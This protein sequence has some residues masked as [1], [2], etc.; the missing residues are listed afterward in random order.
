M[1]APRHVLPSLRLFLAGLLLLCCGTLSAR[2]QASDDPRETT[3]E[4]QLNIT[5]TPDDVLLGPDE[6]PQAW[7]QCSEQVIAAL[8]SK[9]DT[10]QQ[11]ALS[12]IIKY[13][14]YVDAEAAV[15]EVA[16]LILKHPNDNVR[17]LAVTALGRMNNAWGL[18]FLQR[19]VKMET[20]PRVRRTM[21]AVLTASF[22]AKQ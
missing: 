8:K 2:A 6:S 21:L 3:P 7:L 13:G 5:L 9:D 19:M 22:A 12:L 20:A 4:E 14:D 16:D 1:T 17:V 15:Y 18:S 10:H 11:A